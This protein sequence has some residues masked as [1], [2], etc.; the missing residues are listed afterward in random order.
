VN[1]PPTHPQVDAI[2][3]YVLRVLLDHDELYVRLRPHIAYAD[4]AGAI[5]PDVKL[6]IVPSGFF[7]QA[8]GTP[9][10]LPE[11]PLPLVEGIPL[12]FG[13]PVIERV[14][15]RLVVQADIVAATYFLVTRYEEMVRP[16]V[17][18]THGRF[19]GRESLASRHGFLDRPVVD[20][21]AD[22]LRTWLGEAGLPVEPSPRRFAVCL[23]HDVDYVRKYDRLRDIPRRA[24]SV[25]EMIRG[26]CA[27]C[28][29]AH[30]P[31]DV[32][33][34][35]FE[36]DGMVREKLGA[37]RCRVI[38]FFLAGGQTPCDG[39]YDIRGARARGVIGRVMRSGARVGLHTSY[40][41]GLNAECIAPEAETLRSVAGTAV[42]D[43]RYHF[44]GWRDPGH[45]HVLAKAGLTDD[46]TLGY[47]DV[48]GFRLG[49]C[50]PIELFDPVRMEPLGLRGHPLT[51]MDV[52]LSRSEYMGLDEDE[53]LA[54]CE[55][56]VRHTRKH[57]GELTLLWHNT[58]FEKR[59]GQYHP[60]L[61]RR[62]LD[63]LADSP[64]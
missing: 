7:G 25:I 29:L 33:E 26:A 38:Y 21:Y 64:A 48:A 27:W 32:F 49:V 53:A 20:E 46:W 59:P 2:V 57:R 40:E 63:Y 31:Y 37:E 61:Y 36:R 18:D 17:R 34:E 52:T 10:S 56:I 50:R 8:H 13:R 39:L 30:D 14:N 4:P 62:L 12:L 44:L 22:L 35:L 11:N 43:N 51:L 9:D 16:E 41:A 6:C 24:D 28:G 19:P 54:F 45:G 60:R 15:G 55:T 58:E 3:E 42:A 47:A 5:A 23:T 1:A